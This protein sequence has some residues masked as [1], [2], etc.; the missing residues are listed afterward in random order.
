MITITTTGIYEN[1][2]PIATWELPDGVTF[3]LTNYYDFDERDIP[4]PHNVEG[5]YCVI[6][7]GVNRFCSNLNC[8]EGEEKH[9]FSGQ[10]YYCGERDHDPRVIPLKQHK[11][12]ADKD[13][14][15][16][17]V[18]YRYHYTH[19]WDHDNML[20]VG[21]LMDVIR[22][23]DRRAKVSVFGGDIC[24]FYVS[25]DGN[26]IVFDTCCCSSDYD[27]DDHYDYD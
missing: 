4:L 9:A 13:P 19:K 11:V 23:F 27:D 5:Y 1:G 24:D 8:P 15:I 7:N 26:E 12:T 20:T 21:E 10:F 25:D 18:I 17:A 6:I 3:H 2:E 14:L 16:P 22:N